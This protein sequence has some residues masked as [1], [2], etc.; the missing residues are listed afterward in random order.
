MRTEAAILWGCNEPWSV[1]EVELGE[2]V[3]GEVRVKLAAAGLCHS[4]EHLVTGDLPS[5]FPVVGGHEGAGV[6]D[7][8]GPAVT[9]VAPGDHVVL[10]FIPSCGRCQ[11]CA[12]GH[13]N[14]CDLGMHLLAG[15]AIADGTHRITARGTGVGAMC[16]LGT[17]CPYVVVHESSVIPIDDDIPLDKAA[18]LSCGVTTGW[19]SAIYAAEVRSG[20]TVVVV[21]FGGIGANAVQAASH[22]GARFVVVVDP[23]EAKRADAVRFGATHFVTDLNAAFKIVNE[24]TWGRFAEKAIIATGVASGELV[25][26]VM[27]LVGKGGRVVVTAIAPYAQSEISCNLQTLTLFEKQLVGSLFG[28]ANPRADIPRLARLYREGNLLLDELV[29]RTY[30]LERVNEGYEDLREGRNLRGLIVF[31]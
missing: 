29:T 31:D 30:P 12:T 21:G 15:V 23:I 24:I 6:V 7:A 22:A 2:P 10:G 19:G 13:Q 28:S 5:A 16:L 1:E 3:A 14:L 27:S 4:D 26:P 18:L 25:A 11:A 8:V 17:F 20:E 9:S